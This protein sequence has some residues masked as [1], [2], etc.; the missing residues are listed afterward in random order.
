MMTI[1]INLKDDYIITRINA[2]LEEIAKYYFKFPG[3][4]VESID[5]LEGGSWENEYIR[6][7]PLK[8][9]KA[10]PEEM[11]CF[12]LFN[13]IR[14]SFRVEYLKGQA[15]DEITSCGLCRIE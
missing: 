10:S 4:E 12:Q 6:R 2:D 7:T 1:K 9:Y 11:E 14:Y 8:I 15:E 3:M 13:N 5:I